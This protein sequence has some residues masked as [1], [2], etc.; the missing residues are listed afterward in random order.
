MTINNSINAIGGLP[1]T[2]ENGG[3]GLDTLTSGAI[4]V[5]QGTS[6]VALISLD[7]GE[8]LI[9][10][11][12]NDPVAATLT[13][14]SGISITNGAGSITIAST[15]ANPWV[16]VT[17]TSQSM[18]VNTS[19]IANNAALVTLTLPATAAV[20]DT[21]KVVGKGAGLYRIAQ[22]SGQQVH[23]IDVSTTSGATGYVETIERYTSIELVCI[24]EDAEFVVFGPAG[25][26]D[27]A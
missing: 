8:L 21:V 17:G 23:F 12:G 5:G 25:N 16:E 20:G 10:S 9:G 15:G 27:L 14:G 26:F 11:T 24:T 2:V 1:I 18:A 19:Y 4:L 3:T 13:A 6:D 22:N 7:D